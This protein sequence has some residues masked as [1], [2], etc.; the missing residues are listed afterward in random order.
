MSTIN[1]PLLFKPNDEGLLAYVESTYDQQQLCEVIWDTQRHYIRPILGSALYDQLLTQVQNNTLTQLNTTLLNTYINPVMKFYVLGNG[2]YVFNYKMR[3]K[4]VMTMNS[5]NATPATISELD[6][7]Y[8]Y[9]M[10]KGQTDADMLM[11]YLIE[12]EDQ[13]PLYGDPGNGVDTVL[14]KHKQYNVGIYM[15]KYRSGYNPCGTGDENT[16]DF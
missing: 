12:Y 8:K 1:K 10:D 13:Y 11:R 4:G 14:P 6:R 7:L 16:I 2:L 3:Q 5:D 15:G 9:F